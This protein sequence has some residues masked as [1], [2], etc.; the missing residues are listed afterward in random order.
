MKTALTIA[1]FDPSGGAGLQQDLKV[2]SAL[3]VHGLS[4]ATAVTVQNTREVRSFQVLPADLVRDQV[5]ALFS[6]VQPDA[7]KTGMLGS[8]E[9]VDVVY[10]KVREY[11]I[12]KLVVD[13]VIKS[14]SGKHLLDADTIPSLRKLVKKALIATPNK[15]EA[16]V[17]SGVM[18]ENDKRRA[19]A[20]RELGSKF[21]VITE[22]WRGK[23]FIY[24]K[25]TERILTYPTV[26]GMF[27]GTG[28]THSAAI[29][30]YLALGLDPIDSVEKAS[31]FTVNAV[32]SSIKPGRGM[33]V[34][35][36]LSETRKSQVIQQVEAAVNKFVSN[37]DSIKLAPEVGINIVM[38]LSDAESRQHVAGLEGRIVK[39]GSVLKPV[40]RVVFGGSSHMARVVL[41]ALK[42]D[43]TK[44][45]AMNIRYGSEVLR[46][47]KK[48]RLMISSFDRERQPRD[49][50]SMEWGTNQAIKKNGFVPDA[51]YDQGSRGKE[52]M[53]RLLGETPDDVVDLSSRI[54]EYT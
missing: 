12:K 47:C 33:Q 8:K 35:D 28:C 22:G 13:P 50:P 31:E 34:L 36:P 11:R 29:A 9:I 52:A 17:V 45:S 32:K 48:L 16:Q 2:F 6:D 46:A 5:D 30:A 38:A 43:P 27:H 10:R 51:I 40:G 41:T 4:V 37:P 53:V 14:G 42:H 54:L 39:C 15:S 21:V 1:G 18:V 23:N 19:R 24:H 20:A 44:K 3:G 25:G 7:V 26:R 49:T